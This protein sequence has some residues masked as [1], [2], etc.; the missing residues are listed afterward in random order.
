[1]EYKDIITVKRFREKQL[2]LYK[3]LDSDLSKMPVKKDSR[4]ALDENGQVLCFMKCAMCKKDKERNIDNYVASHVVKKDIEA[5]FSHYKAGCES[6]KNGE[7]SPCKDCKA[8]LM[9]KSRTDDPKE[10]LRGLGNRLKIKFDDFMKMWDNFEYTVITCIPR[11]YLV[12]SMNH[13]LAPSVYNVNGQLVFDLAVIQSQSKIKIEDL[14]NIYSELYKAELENQIAHT[15]R[16]DKKY[17]DEIQ[18]WYDRS[19]VENGVKTQYSIDKAKYYNECIKLHLK[20]ILN[21]MVGNHKKDD[22]EAKRPVGNATSGDYLQVLLDNRMRC[23][24]SNIRLS[25]Q[26]GLYTDVS[27]DRIDN[28]QSHNVGNLRPISIIF[29]ATGKR[30]FTR[31]QF[32]HMCLVQNAHPLTLGSKRRITKEHDALNQDCPFCNV[33]KLQNN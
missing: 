16:S 30:Q 6:L 24:I 10:F 11:K 31:K 27:I 5:W 4:W 17:C 7:K 3:E 15:I 21:V 29:Q 33:D 13:Q 22:K 8:E 2:K 14:K 26:K 19:V 18:A 12:P 1:M 20:S 9:N 23:S 25:I 32:L 28:E